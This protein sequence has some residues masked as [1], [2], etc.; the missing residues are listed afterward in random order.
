MQYYAILWLTGA[1]FW[2]PA[3]SPFSRSAITL[4]YWNGIRVLLERTAV[5]LNICP[6]IVH[7][8]TMGRCL[9]HAP[10][11][12]HIVYTKIVWE[13]YTALSFPSLHDFT[14][15]CIIVYTLHEFLHDFL[16]FMMTV[17]CVYTIMFGFLMNLS[18]MT[19]YIAASLPTP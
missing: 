10:T 7:S 8:T 5:G 12:G 16:N 9:G 3:H 19:A 6:A 4:L 15:L 17:F 18:N 11:W 13:K 14:R 2:S 1:A